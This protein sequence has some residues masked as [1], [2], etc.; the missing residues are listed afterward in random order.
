MRGLKLAFAVS[1]GTA[2][3]LLL[4]MFMLLRAHP[5]V[6]AT[7]LAKQHFLKLLML[8]SVALLATFLLAAVLSV[9]IMR[10]TKREV[11]K[12]TRAYLDE[13]VRNPQP[14][15]TRDEHA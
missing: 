10:L 5:A 7:K 6:D 2:A 4:S 12:E 8:N 13:M 15:P 3:V 9:L 1:F 11:A 14:S